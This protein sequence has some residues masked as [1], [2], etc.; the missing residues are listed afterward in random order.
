M[1]CINFFYSALWN[2]TACPSHFHCME[3]SCL[4]SPI[5][6]YEESHAEPLGSS[7]GWVNVDRIFH[8]WVSYS[9]CRS[10]ILISK[11]SQYGLLYFA[12]SRDAPV[13]WNLRN[14]TLRCIKHT[15]AFKAVF[16]SVLQS[17]SLQCVCVFCLFFVFVFYLGYGGLSF[18]LP[19][20]HLN[21]CVLARGQ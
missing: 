7:W 5:V 3:K 13:A 1:G 21:A 11:E 10:E 17:K 20:L 12:I 14:K 4:T 16:K 9:E 15:S 19:S 6:L 18:S 8:F 2:L